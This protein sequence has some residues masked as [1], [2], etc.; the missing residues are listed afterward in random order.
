ANLGGTAPYDALCNQWATAAS[1]NNIA[2]SA[3]IAWMS[4]ANSNAATRLGAP[5]RGFVGASG[6]P[7]AADQAALF[8]P[9]R[10]FYPIR[11]D[12]NGEDRA[13]SSVMTGTQSDGTASNLTCLDWTTRFVSHTAGSAASGPF[14]WTDDGSN[15]CFT[16][17]Y[18]LCVAKIRNAALAV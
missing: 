8:P 4:D 2:G 17:Q 3:Y 10:I 7:F 1:L 15:S 12:P 11:L 6:D 14:H 13:G 16:P 9:Q 18:I 5:P